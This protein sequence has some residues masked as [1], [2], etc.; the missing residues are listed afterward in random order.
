MRKIGALAASVVFCIALGSCSKQDKEAGSSPTS[1]PVPEA[2]VGP[3]A[4][5]LMEEAQATFKPIP[6]GAPRLEGNESTPE[7]LALGR[8]LYFDPRLSAS[9]AISCASCHAIGLGGAD[10]EST[11][12]GHRW[13]RGGRNAP[14]VFN[15]RYNVAQFWDG[16]AKDLFEQAGGPMINP[17]EMA[18]PQEHIEEQLKSLPA[19]TVYFA[20]AFPG[21]AHP[22]TLDNVQKA[23]AVFEATLTTPNAS[24][25]KYLRGNNDALDTRQKAGLRLFMDKG[26]SAC[27]NGVNVGGGR[28]A[29]F[30]V[31]SS[32]GE[33]LLP[34]GDLGRFA[35]TKNE[36]DR[37]VYK[38]PTLRNIA[39]TAPYFHTGQVWD[40]NEAISVMGKV[41]LGADLTPDETAKM[42]AFLTSLTGET[43]RVYIPALP[44]SVATTTRPQ[45]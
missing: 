14:T 27:H 15:A 36:A 6:L 13:Q 43:P 33:K 41:Q 37:Y 17:V 45:D 31:V 42:A 39:L 16:R 38:V 10:N 34:R 23:I 26:C 40:L 25:D 3:A 11:S 7:K 5:K 30:G 22:V 21:S 9:H 35:I 18:S 44:P 1:G 28:Y 8:M 20:K 29:K 12:I 32:P 4:D 2:S 19:Y 24:F